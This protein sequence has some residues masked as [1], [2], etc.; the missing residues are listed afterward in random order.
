MSKT[1][2]VVALPR[3][4]LDIALVPYAVLARTMAGIIKYLEKAAE[5][6]SGRSTVEDIMR[7]VFNNQYSLWVVFDKNASGMLG[8]FALEV[9]NYPSKRML[10][11]QHCVIEPHHMQS[12]EPRMEEISERWA[13]DNGCSGIEFT[14]R[15]GWRRWARERGY[16]S[17]SVVYERFFE[18]PKVEGSDMTKSMVQQ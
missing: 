18:A 8:F 1:A 15:P 9:K 3:V 2:K 7:Y 14:G 13:K 5:V 4:D 11:I 17:H 16:L 12:V 10:C 6:S